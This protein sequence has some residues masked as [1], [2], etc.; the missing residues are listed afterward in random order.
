[1][2]F[3]C[4]RR[5]KSTAIR[6]GPTRRWL[7]GSLLLRKSPGRWNGSTTFLPNDHGNHCVHTSNSA[8]RDRQQ[9][10]S[11]QVDS[12]VGAYLMAAETPQPPSLAEL[13]QR[14]V[15]FRDDRD[16][17]QFQTL[18]NL[19]LSL[20]LEAAELLELS[21]WKSDDQVEAMLD[22][23]VFMGRLSEECADVFL[24]LLLICE[25]AGIDLPTAGAEKIERNAAKYPID[26]ARGNARKYS[27]L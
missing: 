24:Y 9:K 23:T 26:K 10:R 22:D 1:M 25:R 16:W 21:Q 13:T 8:N 3:R 12:A 18:K 15:S 2:I 14:L 17:R 7:S 27:E 6:S 4:L 20:N 11:E 5:A 19:L